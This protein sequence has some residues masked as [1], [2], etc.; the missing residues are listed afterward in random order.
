M[1]TTPTD[2]AE[3]ADPVLLEPQLSP[4][5]STRRPETPRPEIIL[6]PPRR[7]WPWL[8]AAAAGLAVLIWLIPAA[9]ARTPLVGWIVR[10]AAGLQGEIAIGSA[11]LGWFSPVKLSG[12]EI[13]DPQGQPLAEIPQARSDRSLLAILSSSSHVGR[14]RLERPK[15]TLLVRED[16]SNLED[17]LAPYLSPS[18]E[19]SGLVDVALE[20]IDGSLSIRDEQNQQSW[21]I[22]PF[23]LAFTLP[24]DG[25]K[26]LGLR[27][28]GRLVDSER[29]GQFSVQL[30]M[31][32]GDGEP[33]DPDELVIQ[34]D[35][36]PL[37]LLVPVLDRFGV[38]S[39]LGGRLSSQVQCRWNGRDAPG[40]VALQ[41][42]ATAEELALA[43]PPLGDDQIELARLETT[44]AG[45][46]QGERLRLDQLVVESDVGRVSLLGTLQSPGGSLHAALGS[47]PRQAFEMTGR[48]DLARLAAMLPDTLR[49]R[50]GTQVTS[51]LL[52]LALASRRG[53]EGM[54]WHGRVETTNLTAAAY[55]RRLVWEQ[56]I[57]VT[58]NARESPQGPVVENLLC[59]SDFLRLHA[60]GTPDRATASASF[61]LGRLAGQ[62]EGFVDLGGLRLAGDGW[63]R[64]S[65]KR[66]DGER[67]EAGGELRVRNL[68][69][70]IPN[71]PV[72]GDDDLT[73][74]FSATGRA[75]FAAESR[76]DTARLSLQAGADRLDLRLTEPVADFRDG[77]TWPVEVLSEGELARWR[78][79]LAVCQLI[80]CGS[81]GTGVSPVQPQEPGQDARATHKEELDKPLGPWITWGN[82]NAAGAYTLLV[83]GTGSA[84]GA[85]VRKGRLTVEGLKLAGPGL[86]VREPQAELTLSGRWSRPQREVRLP[87]VTLAGSSLSA[88]GDNIVCTFPPG[89]PP[90]L[91]GTIAYRGEL[92]RLQPWLAGAEPPT[93]RLA[94]QISGQATFEHSG[95]V[96][97]AK[98]ETAIDHLAARSRLGQQFHEPQVRFAGR[99]SY[100]ASDRL[101]RLDQAHLSSDTLGL[102]V[103]GRI[104]PAAERADV[105]LAG[106]IDYD[107]EKISELLRPYVGDGVYFAGRGSGP[108]S[109]RGPLDLG[110]AHAD[111]TA[112]WTWGDVYGFRIGPGQVEANLSGGILRTQPLDLAVSEGR[113]RTVPFLRL[114]PEPAEL[115]VEPGRVADQVRLNPSMCRR[116]LQ[117]VA[118]ALA[119]AA[120]AEGRFSI[121]LEQCRIPLAEPARGELAGRMT[122]HSV[123]IGPGP[124]IQE[125]ALLLGRASPAELSR[126]SVIPFRMVDGRI[127]HRDLELVFP[128]VTIRTY[129]SVGLDRSL[130]MMAEM[131]IPPKWRARNRLLDSAFRDQTLRVP[132]GGT[133]DH[134]RIDR[135]ALG[136]LGGQ[137]L[138]DA[139][140]GIIEDQLNQGL[141]RLFGPPR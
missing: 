92:D 38:Q 99:G 109:Y 112:D 106:Q 62:L 76:L 141:D 42:T 59:K 81:G 10:S 52:E 93:W 86:S 79:R 13:R 61:D 107:M 122:I 46:W 51:G 7:W 48:I 25:A 96:T 2:H 125:L 89:G 74:G 57:L 4:E 135:R 56:P 78:P 45:T 110:A 111:A 55:G 73:V 130:A 36:V 101:I 116:G 50:E 100:S 22:E 14:I 123:R 105:Q 16:G 70:A 1:A 5:G 97:A 136:Q 40:A 113:L 43:A 20:I 19:P 82:W 126:E 17:V 28:S 32:L 85:E 64:L 103:A 29:P 140:R 95:G 119:G 114:A 15:L 44:C 3:Y 21:Q 121:D 35:A 63:A 8:A 90:Q 83:E 117:Y 30:S 94:G 71:R 41:G 27:A 33:A 115:Y 104:A 128:D 102:R 108:F 26:P 134:P 54:S 11:S 137:F 84:A 133:L 12:V 23:Q 124:L 65:W 132:I 39:R 67:F 138:E 91:E 37:A 34:T 127:Y 66:P 47:L 77:G 18:E 72:W 75:D 24:A 98:W 6:R 69:V 31:R 120:T 80:N 53:D 68:H 9:V 58:L 129:G 131:P 60:E 49:I 87:S 88:R 118:P 139:A